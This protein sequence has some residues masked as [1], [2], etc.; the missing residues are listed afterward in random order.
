MAEKET[1]EK[2]VTL[3]LYEV[4]QGFPDVG[5]LVYDSCDGTL[6]QIV[7]EGNDITTHGPG[8]GNSIDV[9]A[10]ECSDRMPLDDGEWD[11]MTH[12]RVELRE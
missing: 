9:V 7:H 11:A 5:D 4:G 2:G 8:V 3:R 1:V 6:Y 10:V 12:V